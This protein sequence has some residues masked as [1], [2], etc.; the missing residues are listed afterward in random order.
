MRCFTIQLG[1]VCTIC[2]HSCHFLKTTRF[3]MSYSFYQKSY[4]RWCNWKQSIIYWNKYYFY[5]FLFILP[6]SHWF[7]LYNKIALFLIL[8]GFMSFSTSKV[9]SRRCPLVAV[10]PM[11]ALKCCLT[12]T[13]CHGHG[14]WH[15][16]PSQYTDTGPTCRCAFR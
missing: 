6:K 12:E 3:V 5:L 8:W 10:V 13:P 1:E 4:I 16:T 9:I 11:T 14:T 7:T 15:P 2:T